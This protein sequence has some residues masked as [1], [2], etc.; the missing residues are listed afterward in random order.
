MRLQQ[1]IKSRKNS[2]PR[3]S[4]YLMEV[5]KLRQVKARDRDRMKDGD[6]ASK[7]AARRDVRAKL[8][9]RR[10]AAAPLTSFR[11][12]AMP[13]PDGL[14]G[15]G[16]RELLLKR[17]PM[18]ARRSWRKPSHPTST[19]LLASTSP[20]PHS[21]RQSHPWQAQISRAPMYTAR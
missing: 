13:G 12:A 5:M 17:R 14:E 21:M 15:H 11:R 9:T 18:A 6:E 19:P 3:D 2:E 16:W 1:Q 8:S 7:P 10:L 20:S 4:K